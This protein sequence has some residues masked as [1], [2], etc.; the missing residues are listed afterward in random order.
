MTS[1]TS[2]LDQDLIL[3]VK[4]DKSDFILIK[5]KIA[6]S[7]LYVITGEY[8]G[9]TG[10]WYTS[11]NFKGKFFEQVLDV[12]EFAAGENGVLSIVPKR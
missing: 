3:V 2:N 1:G 8:K 11:C 4:W 6:L 12:V 10:N 7:Q 9:C 5:L